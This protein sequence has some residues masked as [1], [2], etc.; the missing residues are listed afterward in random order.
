[1]N[2]QAYVELGWSVFPVKGPAYGKDYSDTKRPLLGSWKPYQSRKPTPDEITEWMKNYPKM[3]LAAPTGP[4]NGFFVIDIDSNDWV[5]TFPN[6]EFGTTWKSRSKRGCHYFYKWEDWMLNIPSTGSEIGK[7]KGFDIRGQGGYVVIPNAAEPDRAWDFGPDQGPIEPLPDWC[8]KFLLETF[9]PNG[10]KKKTAVLISEITD[11]NRHASFLSLTGKLHKRAEMSPAEILQ[12][13]S[14]LA[15]KT[16]FTEEIGPLITD[17]VNRYPSA[18]R[19]EALRPESMQALLTEPEP[20]LEWMING[21]WTD[22]AKGFI[23]GH[24]GTGKTWIAL[25]MMLAVATGGLCMG[26]YQAAYKAPCLII[27]EEASRRNLQRRIHSLARA[28]QLSPADLSSVFH[29]TQQFSNVPRDTQE[30]TDIILERGIKFVVFDSLREVHSAKENSADEMAIILRAF[31]EISVVGNCALL[32]IHHLSKSGVDST[33]KSIFERMRG[34]GSLWAWRDCILGIEGEE[35]STV[36]KCSFQFRDAD[37]PAPIKITRHVG[38]VSGAIALEAVGLEESVDFMQKIEE[39][40]AFV[41]AQLAG[42]SSNQI[43]K[44]IG[45]NRSDVLATI[46]RMNRLG[47]LVKSGA[48]YVVPE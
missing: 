20:A 42:A 16:G 3:S 2:L 8:K 9:V 38:A 17:V 30:L 4:I 11:G 21:L 31:K 37:S 7:I 28:R 26:K 43:F 25:D 44:A 22:K 19:R 41:R 40:L 6:A 15:E 48:V 23:A 29:I 36:C 14:P 24:P 46:K 10:T 33:N 35:E 27:E 39:I 47:K 32:L 5:K 12:I 1:M 34:T 45:G 13:L 18:N